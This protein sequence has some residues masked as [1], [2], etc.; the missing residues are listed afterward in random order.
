MKFTKTRDLSNPYDTTEVSIE[1][2]AIGLP[3]V[4]GDFLNFLRAC[5]YSISPE[6][7]LEI[8]EEEE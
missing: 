2:F 7:S 1:T 5:G 4:L 8:V 3:E 6:A